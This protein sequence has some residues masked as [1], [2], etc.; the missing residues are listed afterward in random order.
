METFLYYY[1]GFKI[2]PEIQHLSNLCFNS[3]VKL[4]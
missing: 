3:G 1:I 2:V 4:S